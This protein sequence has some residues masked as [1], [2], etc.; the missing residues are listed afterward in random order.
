MGFRSLFASVFRNKY[1]CLSA[2]DQIMM[3]AFFGARNSLGVHV[4]MLIS[5]LFLDWCF[6]MVEARINMNDRM[7]VGWGLN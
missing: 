7:L 3:T 5:G 2:V 1:L 6:E 4:V